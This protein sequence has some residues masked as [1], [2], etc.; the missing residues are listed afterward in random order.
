MM[1]F[2]STWFNLKVATCLNVY[3][4]ETNSTKNPLLEGNARSFQSQSEWKQ[5]GK[6]AMSIDTW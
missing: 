6:L 1:D 2:V 5:L 3:V 4:F